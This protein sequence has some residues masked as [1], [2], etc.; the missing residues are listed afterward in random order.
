MRR[1]RT[2]GLVGG[3]ALIV[4]VGQIGRTQQSAPP[5]GTDWPMYRHDY[6]G[7]GYSPLAQINTKNVS[8]L[9]EVWSYRLSSD[10]QNSQATPI[11]VNGSMYLPAANRV[12]SLDPETGTERWQHI[13]SDGVPSR[14]GVAYWTGEAG[15]SRIVFTAGRRLIALDAATGN[16]AIGFGKDGEVDI[17]VP[18]QL[19][20]AR[21]PER[22]HGWRE[23]PARIGRRARQ[24]ARV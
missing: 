4:L 19:G 14:R 2:V 10:A 15:A 22:R 23:Q 7:T 13:V 3:C 9:R 11:V 17:V 18:V 16:P 24:R 20:S 8:S 5:S 1:T 21:V 6:A 12:V